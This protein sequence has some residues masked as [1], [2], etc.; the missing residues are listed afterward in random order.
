[1]I[2]LLKRPLDHLLT[3]STV[4]LT[5][6]LCGC[7]SSTE[8]SLLNKTLALNAG[9]I[10]TITL[11]PSETLLIELPSNP[12]TGYRWDTTQLTREGRC[13]F[14]K[15]TEPSTTAKTQG[16][17][18]AGAPGKQRWTLRLD[19]DFPCLTEQQITWIYRRSWESRSPADPT[20]TIRLQ[21]VT[22]PKPK[23]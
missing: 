5:V 23:L 14:L 18:V 17:V 21:A 15:E 22:I 7:S 1:M 3:I 19:P 6:I 11:K 20:A 16:A 10:K 13:Y 9:D 12:S 4:C 2:E 8:T